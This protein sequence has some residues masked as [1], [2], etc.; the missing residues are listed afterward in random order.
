MTVEEL[1]VRHHELRQVVSMESAPRAVAELAACK[2][3]ERELFARYLGTSA[4]GN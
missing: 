2:R 4:E 3:I 1:A